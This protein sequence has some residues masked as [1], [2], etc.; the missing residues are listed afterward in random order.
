MIQEELERNS[1]G[2]LGRHNINGEYY[3]D[4]DFG[5]IKEIRVQ[6]RTLLGSKKLDVTYVI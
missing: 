5:N 4:L 2:H 3:L 6:K 1:K